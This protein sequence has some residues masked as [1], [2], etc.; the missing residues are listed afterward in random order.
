MKYIITVSLL[1]LISCGGTTH[2]VKERRIPPVKSVVA[3]TSLYLDRDFVGLSTPDESVNLA[4][5]IAGQVLDFPVYMGE[6]VAN[7]ELL[8]RLDPQDVEL[9]LA[10]DRSSYEQAKSN[11]SR[12]RRLLEH[13]AVSQQEFETADASFIRARSV[14]ENS[15]HLLTETELRAPF[16][17]IVERTYVE[18]Y[19]RVQAG[20]AVVR[21]VTPVSMTVDF[22]IP[23]SSLAALAD[24]STLFNV[25]FDAYK[26]VSFPA[27]IREYAKTSSDAS[28]FPVSLTITDAK[29]YTIS[30][31]MSC[32]IT[33][34]VRDN[35][36]G[37]LIALPISSIYAPTQGGTYVWVIDKDNTV[38]LQAIELGE[39]T[40]SNTVI[41]KNGVESGERIVTAGVYQLTS[42]ERVKIIK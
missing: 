13:D 19:Q 16:K 42:G 41:I 26:G 20:E 6:N 29:G 32:V 15:R 30:S 4:F 33:M 24:S 31:G 37:N 14:Y 12:I 36:S 34:S 27:K 9:Q 35:V 11:L 38:R 8:A 7:G 2:S 25:S 40:G 17:A 5:K 18:P 21:L 39:I 23:E 22:T 1:G 3:E 28:G 10:A